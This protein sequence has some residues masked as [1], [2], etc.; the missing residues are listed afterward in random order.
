M[1]VEHR[2]VRGR[3]MH[4][5]EWEAERLQHIAQLDLIVL[6]IVVAISDERKFVKREADRQATIGFG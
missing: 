6:A 3:W 5:V 1:G 2:E 4:F